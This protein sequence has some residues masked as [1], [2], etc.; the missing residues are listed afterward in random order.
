MGFFNRMLG[1]TKEIEIYSPVDGEIIN[2][3]NVP[4]E[5]FASGAI[6]DGIAINPSGKVICAPCN[7][8]EV[9]IFETNHAVSFETKGGLELIVHF[10]VDTVKLKGKGFERVGTDG[11]SVKKGDELVKYD[12]DF[13]RENA[14]SVLTPVIISNMELVDSIEKSTG[15]V[16][17]GDLIMKIKLKNS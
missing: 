11:E 6:G 5:A 12:I 16:K 7:A 10:G 17:I 14:E 4:D 15:K 3:S 8:E 13:L 9:S 2:L 1:K